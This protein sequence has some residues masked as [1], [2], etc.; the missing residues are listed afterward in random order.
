[1]QI[2]QTIRQNLHQ[3]EDILVQLNDEEYSAP[4]RILNGQSIGKHVRHIVEF[5]GCLIHAKT[6]VCYDARERD[7]KI[8]NST[9]YCIQYIHQLLQAIEL[10]NLNESIYLKQLV[11][12]EP[13]EIGT[14]ISRE[15]I[16][17]IDHSI[18]HFAIIK[19]AIQHHLPTIIFDKNFGIAYSTIQ[20]N[21]HT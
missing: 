19:I 17:C 5:Y 8:E 7:E 6:N 13:I 12:D 2:K 3:L 4:L 18:H 20:Y 21:H 1:M 16:Y 15:M 14:T 10:L 11:N 9:T